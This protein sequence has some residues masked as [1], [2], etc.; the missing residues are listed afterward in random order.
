MQRH[1]EAV[2]EFLPIINRVPGFVPARVQLA[3][4]YA[5]MDRISDA[6][7]IVRSIREIAPKYSLRSAARM[8]PYPDDANRTRLIGALK[9]AGLPQ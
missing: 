6:E 4:T 5:E 9:M 2:S 8:F 1:D 3:R 7:D